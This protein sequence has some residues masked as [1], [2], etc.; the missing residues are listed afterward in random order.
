GRSTLARALHRASGRRGP[1]VEVDPATVPAT[2]FESELFGHR[3]GAFTGATG[4]AEGRVARAEG[5]TLVLDQ[6]EEIPLAAQ[7]K[8]LRLLAERRYRPLGGEERT[9]TV[10]FVALGS[11][12]LPRRVRQGLF[13]ADLYYRLEVLAFRVPPL[14]ERRGE[15]PALAGAL[16]ADLGA[17][18][19]RPAPPLA[20]DALAWMAE[21]AWPGNLRELRNVLERAMVLGD[22]AALDPLPPR[23]LAGARPRPLVEVEREE[24]AKALAHTR[25]H[26]GKAAALLG[27][28]RKALWEKRK[29]YG[30]P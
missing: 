28:S 20:T 9:A 7:P 8:L 17:R 13:R 25:G 4:D 27:I 12:S 2:L 22:G 3:A 29:R 21:H 14:R 16:L 23:E 18:L 10:R 5:G 30:I 24:I 6:V 19:G 11:E 1:L 15:L 26:Q